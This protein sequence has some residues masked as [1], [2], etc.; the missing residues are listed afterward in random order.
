MKKKILIVAAHPDDD[1]LGC[2]GFISKFKKHT[3]RVI[4][5]AE[6]SS[7]RFNNL[8]KDRDKILAAIK[9]RKNMSIKALKYLKVKQFFYY[10]NPCGRLDTVPI[11]KL[12]KIL[13]NEISNFSPNIILTHS[14]NDCNN[15]HRIVFRSV[16]MSTRPNSKF[17]VP[18]IM[19]FE[20]LSSSEWNYPKYF[21]PNKFEKMERKNIIEKYNALKFFK[22]EVQ[23]RPLPRNKEG[24]FTLAK[25]RGLQ[26]GFEFAEAY[27]I[28][29]SINR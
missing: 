28:I 12:N 17:T 7:C 16:M 29:R 26:S 10:E 18:T 2:G 1:I 9:K 11:I 24:L 22:T 8:T 23:K 19:S 5:L 15:D 4:F 6:G 25:Y 3:I 20:I 14:E 13:E 27:K 21:E